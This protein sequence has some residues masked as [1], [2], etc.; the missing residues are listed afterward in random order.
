MDI[1]EIIK[2]PFQDKKWLT[3][4]LLMGVFLLIP[5]AGALN[6]LGYIKACYQAFHD[7]KTELPEA[8]LSYIGAGWWLFVAMLPAVGAIILLVIVFQVLGFVAFK[9]ARGLAGVV[10]I[11]SMLAMLAAWLALAVAAPAIIYLHVVKGER[12]ASA[13][14]GEIIALIKADAGVYMMLWLCFLVAGIIG[15]LGQLACGIGMLVTM[16]LGYAMQGAALAAFA[17]LQK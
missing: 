15:G 4:S 9:I 5:I 6:L 1:G 3:K 13:K 11:V 7:G 8:N 17:K 14:F 16:P 2:V 12:W 10:G